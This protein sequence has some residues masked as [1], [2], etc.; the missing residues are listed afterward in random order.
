MTEA[1]QQD[2]WWAAFP[3]PRSTCP[4]ITAEE[5]MKLLDDM[6]ITGR[7]SDFLLVDVR[8]TDWEVC[9]KFLEACISSYTLAVGSRTRI[10]R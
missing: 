2:Q 10:T 3:A 9:Y 6:D 7:P 1:P 8:R 4:T 5:V